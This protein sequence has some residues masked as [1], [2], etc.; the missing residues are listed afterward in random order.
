M[1]DTNGARRGLVAQLPRTLYVAF[2]TFGASAASG[3]VSVAAAA[4]AAAV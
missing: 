3:L 4:A 2:A 1:C